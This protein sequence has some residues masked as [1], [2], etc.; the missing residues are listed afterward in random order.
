MTTAELSC[1][2]TENWLSHFT[3]WK[4]EI[5]Q[6]VLYVWKPFEHKEYSCNI[7]FCVL[8]CF[9]FTTIPITFDSCQ[10]K[11]LN[12]IKW[13]SR[14]LF[15]EKVSCSDWLNQSLL[16]HYLTSRSNFFSPLSTLSSA[17]SV[18]DATA[19]SSKLR[20][21][22]EREPAVRSGYKLHGT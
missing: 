21:P 15:I 22:E 11:Y 18:Y 10:I 5:S 6:R 19:S 1:A 9:S 14:C 17:L 8:K 13:I 3:I 7:L 2:S 4:T 12:L 16:L 20:W